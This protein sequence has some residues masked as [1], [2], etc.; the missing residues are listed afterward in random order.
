MFVLNELMR[1]CED[2]IRITSRVAF[3]NASELIDGDLTYAIERLGL[4]FSRMGS[5]AERCQELAATMARVQKDS[6]GIDIDE[7]YED[8]TAKL[9]LFRNTQTEGLRILEKV[10]DGLAQMRKEYKIHF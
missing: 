2:V 8:L 10:C 3:A 5:Q 1:D 7:I 4:A 9:N 6:V